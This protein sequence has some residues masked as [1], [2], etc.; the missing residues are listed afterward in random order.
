MCMYNF[1]YICVYN[2]ITLMNAILMGIM[3]WWISIREGNLS[4]GWKIMNIEGHAWNFNRKGGNKY[5]YS[6]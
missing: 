5:I 1:S 6:D 3:G 4:Y 2:H